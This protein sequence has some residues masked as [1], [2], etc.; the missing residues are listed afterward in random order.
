M[1]HLNTARRPA[2]ATMAEVLL[3]RLSG[4]WRDP[5]DGTP[6]PTAT[7]AAP[8]PARPADTGHRL[9]GRSRSE[10]RPLIGSHLT[11][12]WADHLKNTTAKAGRCRVARRPVQ[13]RFPS[14][15]H[16]TKQCSG[17]KLKPDWRR[18]RQ[19]G[20]SL[21]FSPTRSGHNGGFSYWSDQRRESW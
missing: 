17:F 14:W 21:S 15:P 5:A 20:R 1:R 10:R 9:T 12:K 19:R 13:V 18:W 4:V 6:R 2:L 16:D 8:A 3:T 7:G 11:D